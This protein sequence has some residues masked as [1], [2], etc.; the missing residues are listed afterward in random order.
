MPEGDTI[1]RA[2]R[3]LHRALAGRQVTGFESVYPQLT[4]V[5][6][7]RPIV[8]RT[9]EG[10]SARGKHLLIAFSNDLILRTHMRMSGSWHIYRPGEAWRRPRRDLRILV[11]TDAFVAVGFNIPIAEFETSRSIERHESLGRLGPDLLDPAFDEA[12]AVRRLGACAGVPVAIALIDQRVMAGVGNV[13]KSETLFLCGVHP[14]ARADALPLDRRQALV[15]TARRLLLAN[16]GR[17]AG[18]GIVTYSGLRRT[19]RRAD[20]AERLW[21]YGRGG[22]PCRRCATP[23]SAAK[24][25]EE[26]RITYWCGKCQRL[27]S[28]EFGVGDAE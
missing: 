11:A 2:A 15:A 9:I 26:A 8:G 13:Y 4:R 17:D 10:V 3:T 18:D 25:G 14:E 28:A 21:V 20:P 24:Q 22:R 19:T 1:F 12:E 6:D 7:D 27:R 16:V 23:I 5:H